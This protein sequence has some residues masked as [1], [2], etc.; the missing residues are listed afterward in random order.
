MVG[1]QHT[2]GDAIITIDNAGSY[3]SIFEIGTTGNN[4]FGV[5]VGGT[6]VPGGAYGRAGGPA[7][8]SQTSGLA[9][10]TAAAGTTFTLHNNSQGAIGLSTNAGG[11]GI[12]SN[13]A[14][15][16]HRLN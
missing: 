6:G 10:F 1:I 7:A 12:V 4:Q 16:I 15:V 8:N 11:A 13:A 5:L 14:V 3:L 9:I 2:A